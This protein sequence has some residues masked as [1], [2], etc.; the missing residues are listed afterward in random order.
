MEDTFDFQVNRENLR[1]TRTVPLP[2]AADAELAPGEALL[3]V[4][5]FALTAN[6]ITYAVFGDAMNYWDFF[7]AEA[8]WGRVPVWGFADVVRSA[9]DGVE[10]GERLYGYFPMA[11]WL[12]VEPTRIGPHGFTDGA[13]HRQHLHRVYNSYLR[14]AADPGYRPDLEAQ[15]MLLRPLFMTSFLIDD[16]LA[17]NDFFGARQ[18]VITS[19]S[20]KT[21]LGL[22][23]LLHRQRGDQI[24]VV[25][26][27]SPGNLAFCESLGC[28]HTVRDYAELE[29]LP[30]DVPTVVVDM[31]G[32]GDVLRR[33]HGHFDAA[34]RYSC[35][36]GGTHWE[37]RGGAGALPGPK[38]EL[39]F[40]PAQV[41][42]RADDWGP[43]GLEAR[44]GEA[45]GEFVGSTEGWFE[46][47]HE[48]GAEAFRRRY[49]ETLEGRVSPTC[50]QLLSP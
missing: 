16:F 23:H 18:I 35:L 46:V 19:A 14:V 10:A 49:L 3:A 37:A 39:F 30:A 9:A 48:R 29:G 6:N 38:P 45:W 22:A 5:V 41:Q 28:Y 4:D 43:G 27:T 17:D 33:L 40:A 20:S 11:S 21:A 42:K 13:A 50:G 36:V 1:E 12:R 8:G 34:L 15:Q 24:R 31:A 25:G 32:N 44:V 26:L 47:R 7:P 2:T